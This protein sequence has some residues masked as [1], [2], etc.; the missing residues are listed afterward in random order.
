MLAYYTTQDMGKIDDLLNFYN[1]IGLGLG[2]LELVLK[3][4]V[5]GMAVLF[6][7]FGTLLIVPYNVTTTPHLP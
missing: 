1:Y 4:S 6:H 7:C 5:K 2:E 3:L